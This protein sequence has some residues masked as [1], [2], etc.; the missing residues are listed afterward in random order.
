MQCTMPLHWNRKRSGTQLQSAGARTCSSSVHHTS[1]LRPELH[2]TPT[3]THTHNFPPPGPLTWPKKGSRVRCAGDCSIIA[4]AAVDGSRPNNIQYESNHLSTTFRTEHL[5]HR[6]LR[7]PCKESPAISDF[8]SEIARGKVMYSAP[9]SA[10]SMGLRGRGREY[11]AMAKG[12]ER[13]RI[14]GQGCVF[15]Y[16]KGREVTRPRIAGVIGRPRHRSAVPSRA[17][18]LF[19]RWRTKSRNLGW[20]RTRANITHERRGY[21]DR[22]RKGTSLL[23]LTGHVRK[24]GSWIMHVLYSLGQI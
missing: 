21:V 22:Q 9:R 1:S 13:H 5:P 23:L 24:S 20:L 3:R 15:A 6:L 4:V 11:D 12:E 8:S 7:N 16:P 10:I 18:H 14:S 17:T 2:T 19:V